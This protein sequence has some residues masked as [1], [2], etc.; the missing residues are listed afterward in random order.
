VLTQLQ[1]TSVRVSF[2]NYTPDLR[3]KYMDMGVT[4]FMERPR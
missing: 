3:Q 4:V 1:G 2:R